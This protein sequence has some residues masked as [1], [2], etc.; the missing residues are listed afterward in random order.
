MGLMRWLFG[1]GAA[2]TL[3]AAAGVAEVFVPNATRGQE[4]AASARAAALAQHA[5]EFGH[6][7]TGAF[8]RMV[9]GLN[10]LP[11][12]MLALGTIGLFVFAMAD[13]AAFAVRMRGL[14]EVPEPLWWLLGVIVGFYFGA[15]EAHHFRLTRVA[16]A[17]EP[18]TRPP[19]AA[20]P[21]TGEHNAALAEWRA[22]A[23]G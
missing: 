11:R 23:A 12:P 4:L 3:D 8:D 13:P 5:A 18:G 2:R 15:R 9:D 22:L 19:A 20:A 14:A 17:P 7:R 21:Q 16:A 1:A 10:R 6:A